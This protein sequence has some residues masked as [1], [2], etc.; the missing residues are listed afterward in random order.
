MQTQIF[1]GTNKWAVRAK[2]QAQRKG[3]K[4][5]KKSEFLEPYQ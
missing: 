1:S 3:W 4:L 5:D 2:W